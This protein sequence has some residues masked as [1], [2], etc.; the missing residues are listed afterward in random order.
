MAFDFEVE[1]WQA[2]DFAFHD[3]KPTDINDTYGVLV[4]AVDQTT[5]EFHYF[6]AFTYDPFDTW[7]DWLDYIES[8]M[9]MYELPVA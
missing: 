5:G 4:H 7:E 2:E 1:R 6:W 3:G 9:D 8:M